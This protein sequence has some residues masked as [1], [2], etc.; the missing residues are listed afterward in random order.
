VRRPFA[1]PLE[2]V[3]LHPILMVLTTALV[4]VVIFDA[5]SDRPVTYEAGAT[6]VVGRV[7]VPANAVPGYSA[8]NNTLA[9][10]YARF[11]GTDLHLD[12]M[13]TLSG[14]G[15]TRD[16][17]RS[18]GTLSA[19]N[20][21]E[22]SVIRLRAESSSGRQARELADLSAKALIEVVLEVNDPANRGA[23]LLE[24]HAA[25]SR[26]LAAAQADLEQ[27]QRDLA[28]FLAQ[29]RPADAAAAQEQLELVRADFQQQQ[30]RVTT[31]ATLYQESQRSRI[32]GPLLRPLNSAVVIGDSSGAAKQLGAVAGLV[33]GL[34]VALALVWLVANRRALRGLRRSVIVRLEGAPDA[35]QP[36]RDLSIVVG[37]WARPDDEL[38]LLPTAE[39]R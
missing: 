18:L 31:A 21:P 19:S 4:A 37:N 5:Y 2:A 20:V 17:I 16:D 24:N 6:V 25:A 23:E 9:G 1:S 13:A 38:G 15:I 28:F 36:N 39:R 26:S 32:D 3:I 12:R 22:A 34:A 35:P 33:A 10:A 7:D 29:N 11:V 14:T 8:A 30:L 27:L